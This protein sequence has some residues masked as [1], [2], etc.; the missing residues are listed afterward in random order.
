MCGGPSQS[1]GHALRC[2]THKTEEHGI[3]NEANE[4]LVRLAGS[5]GA[6]AAAA[7]GAPFAEPEQPAPSRQAERSDRRAEPGV[8]NAEPSGQSDELPPHLATARAL[9][10]S[11]PPHVRLG[12]GLGSEPGSGDR[13]GGDAVVAPAGRAGRPAEAFE[14]GVGSRLL[15]RLGPG[16]GPE[17]QQ[18]APPPGWRAGGAHQGQD[19]GLGPAERGPEAGPP[20]ADHGAPAAPRPTKRL[21]SVIVRPAAALAGAPGVASAGVEAASEQAGQVAAGRAAPEGGAAPEGRAA[22]EEPRGAGGAPARAG[23]Q[24][25]PWGGPG[26][27]AADAVLS[28][29]R[30]RLTRASAPRTHDPAAAS[31]GPAPDPTPGPAPDAGPGEPAPPAEQAGGAVARDADGRAAAAQA[32]PAAPPPVGEPSAGPDPVGEHAAAPAA[33]AARRAAPAFNVR[34]LEA[35]RAEK[36]QQREAAAAAPGEA[37]GVEGP[38]DGAPAAAPGEPGGA[39]AQQAAA[40][41][42]APAAPGGAE[43]Q[44][45]AA[46]A[47]APAAPGGDAPGRAAPAPASQRPGQAAPAPAP[48]PAL[49]GGA[50]GAAGGGAPARR[51]RLPIVFAPPAKPAPLAAAAAGVQERAAADVQAHAGAPAAAD[52]GPAGGPASGAEEGVGFER[53]AAGGG[54]G[55]SAAPPPPHGAAPGAAPASADAAPAPAGPAAPPEAGAPPRPAGAPTAA[56]AGG[57]AQATGASD[58]ERRA[59]AGGRS[60]AQAAPKKPVYDERYTKKD[61]VLEAGGERL[62]VLPCG[63]VRVAR[64]F[65]HDPCCRTSRADAGSV[66]GRWRRAIV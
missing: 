41:A 19:P 26:D 59:D 21:R 6:P 63:S 11:L 10:E 8:A 24:A 30:G 45:A 58:G 3:T 1:F 31:P 49:Q 22:G 16:L 56:A 52:G 38:R 50:G 42:A 55:S 7:G 32:R 35:I 14:K 28:R 48:A 66:H 40:P 65:L 29:L 17:G 43:A 57:P 4:C 23:A 34:S 12:A 25:K 39:E 27:A 37:G 64:V 62:E 46:P 15:A 36:A 33:A 47:A 20:G 2:S 5:K 9:A 18:G 51:K 61:I 53:A 54:A 44:Q 13:R 60:G